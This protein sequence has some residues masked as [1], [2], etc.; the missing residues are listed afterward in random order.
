LQ[1]IAARSHEPGLAYETDG[2][3]DA[4][5]PTIVRYDLSSNPLAYVNQSFEFNRILLQS[6]SKRHPK[7]GESYLYFTRRLRGILLTNTRNAQLAAN[8]I[9]GA[10]VR[11]VIRSASPA[12]LPFTPVS[13]AQQ[14]QA[15]QVL[16]TK[17]FAPELYD[18]PAGSYNRTAADPFN[19][20]DPNFEEGFPFREVISRS[21]ASLLGSLLSGAR[22]RRMADLEFKFKKPGEVLPL[23]ELFPNLRRAVWRDL[24]AKSVVPPLQRDLQREHLRILIELQAGKRPGAPADAR[25]VAENELRQ[26]KKQLG[27]T[28]KGSPDAYT[29]LHCAEALR[30]IDTALRDKLQW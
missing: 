18:V 30:R 3:V 25:A 4:Y 23:T 28:R 20:E 27:P 8:Y 17:F 12:R 13:A 19:F 24:S 7:P 5:D 10:K 21:R 15:L 2:A 16:A 6:L 29:R 22:L 26:L 14:R 1:K 9:G 11:R